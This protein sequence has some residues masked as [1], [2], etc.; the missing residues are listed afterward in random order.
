VRGTAGGGGDRRLEAVADVEHDVGRL[1]LR[2]RPRCELEVVRLGALRSQV[3]DAYVGTPDTL[4]R[5][6]ERIEGGDDGRAP[7]ATRTATAGR[8]RRPKRNEN[9]SRNHALEDTLPP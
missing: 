8:E 2:N 7:V 1:E 3:L 5:V 6:R 9:D 4:G